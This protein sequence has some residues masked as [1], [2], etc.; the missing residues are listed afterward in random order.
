MKVLVV[1][2]NA[3]LILERLL[4]SNGKTTFVRSVAT[5]LI[6]IASRWVKADST[7]LESLKTMRRKLGRDTG[8][9]T[10]KNRQLIL[11]LEDEKILTAFMKNMYCIL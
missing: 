10:R 4:E 2:P 3:K 9:M 6:T 8:G 1:T 11:L 5:E 7:T